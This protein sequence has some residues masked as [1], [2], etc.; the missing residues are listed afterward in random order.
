M[1]RLPS[2]HAM[3]NAGNSASLTA[4]LDFGAFKSLLVVIGKIELSLAVFLLV[5][6]VEP[7]PTVLRAY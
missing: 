5:I 1:V 4:M 7:L 6:V 2:S 3:L